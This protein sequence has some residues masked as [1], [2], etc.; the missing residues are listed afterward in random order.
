MVFDSLELCTN[1]D[2]CNDD[3]VD[4]DKLLRDS[5]VTLTN[6]LTNKHW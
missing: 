3:A 5:K 6:E 1:S 2:G 4:T